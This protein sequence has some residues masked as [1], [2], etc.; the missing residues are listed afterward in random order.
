MERTRLVVEGRAREAP[1]PAFARAQRQKV[2]SGFRDL[3]E[4][5]GGTGLSSKAGQAALN[6]PTR[7]RPAPPSLDTREP[8]NEPRADQF[9]GPS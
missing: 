6:P 5:F 4:R 3:P 2:L 1:T 9:G 7:P 8:D